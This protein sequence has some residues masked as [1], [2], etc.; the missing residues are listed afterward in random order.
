MDSWKK[1]FVVIWA[2]Q[3]FSTLSSAVVGYAV[4]FWLSITTGS[5]EV[6]AFSFIATFLPQLLLGPFTGV[7]I[8]RWDRKRIMIAADVFIALCSAVMAALFAFGEIRIPYVYLLLALRSVGGAFHA[9]AMQASVP[10]L[11]PESELLRVTGVNQVIHSTSTLAGPALAALL[12]NAFDMTY[13][14]LFDV[15]GAAVAC[16]TLALVHIPN[17]PKKADAPAPHVFREMMEGLREVTD[18]PGLLWVFVFVLLV[19]FCIFPLSALFPLMT[20]KHFAGGTTQMSIVE[21]AWGLGMLLGGTLLGI[22]KHKANKVILINLTYLVLGAAFFASGMLPPSGFS[23]FVGLTFVGG[24][25]G[26]VYGGVFTVV[27]QTA[28]DPAA[29]GRVFSLYASI[30]LTPALFGVLQTGFVADRIGIVNVFLVTGGA[31]FALGAAAFLVPP[32]RR[33]I[34]GGDAELRRRRE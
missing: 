17:P 13:A 5:A 23:L 32:I 14:L 20:T 29:L 12:I 3:L 2:G 27:V 15:A 19:T 26:A 18:R 28:V 31:L 6:L 10:L 21:I 8:D 16:V 7:L 9:P 1:T 25:A 4:V 22:L 33:V 24:L 30:M 11:A 34:R